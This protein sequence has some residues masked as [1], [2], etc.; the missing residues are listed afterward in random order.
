MFDVIDVAD[1]EAAEIPVT[2]EFCGETS[3]IV[4]RM[5]EAGDYVQTFSELPTC[6]DAVRDRI[7]EDQGQE[8]LKN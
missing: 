3:V 7:D 2:C 4:M 1:L 8:S 6:C 5:V